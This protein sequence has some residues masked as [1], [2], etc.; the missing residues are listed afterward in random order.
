MNYALIDESGRLSDPRDPVFV[1]AMIVSV[2]LP[3]LARIIPAARRSIPPKGKTRNERWLAEIKFSH[4]GDGTKERVLTRL[5]KSPIT[6]Y[7]LVVIKEGRSIAD[8]PENLAF[9]TFRLVRYIRKFSERPKHLLIDRHFTSVSQRATFDKQLG[10]ALGYPVFIEHLDSQQHSVICLADF[11]A[12]A[13]REAVAHENTR[14]Y[15][16]LGDRIAGEERISWRQL[17]QQQKQK[18]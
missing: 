9:L 15:D 12:G 11:V 18:R 6:V 1:L 16:L 14:W 17:R 2:D 5:G 4:V 10:M 8:T 7:A 3:V 13:I